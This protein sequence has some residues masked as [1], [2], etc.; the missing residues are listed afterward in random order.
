[1]DRTP[2]PDDPPLAAA[3]RPC[4]GWVGEPIAASALELANC[5]RAVADIS[6]TASRLPDQRP[7]LRSR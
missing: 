6:R 1:M 3:F 2:L 4:G 7:L 5:A